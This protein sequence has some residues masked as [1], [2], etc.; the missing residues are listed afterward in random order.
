MARLETKPPEPVAASASSGANPQQAMAGMMMPVMQ[1][2]M[3]NMMMMANLQAS[4]MPMGGMMPM[5][6]MMMM[7]M[8]G[9]GMGGCGCPMGGM[10]SP[11]GM[12]PGGAMGCP[13][14]GDAPAVQG[15]ASNGIPGAAP[16]PGF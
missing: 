1:M 8:P 13:A 14:I 15:D 5:A 16:C 2:P 6:N 3:A 9:G 11:M 7:G 12:G 10:A 4:M